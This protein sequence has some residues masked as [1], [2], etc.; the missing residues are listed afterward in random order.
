[1]VENILVTGDVVV[2]PTPQIAARRMGSVG[3]MIFNRPERRNAVSLEMWHAIP[4][5]MARFDA[6]PDIRSIVLAGAG[7]DAFIAGAD[8][9]EFEGQRKDAA[10]ALAYE[11]RNTAAYRA[12]AD[13]PKS[14]IAMI[15]GYC[16]GGGV[17]IAAACDIRIAADGA[18]FG[19]PAARLGLAYPPFAVALLLRAVTPSKAKLLIHSARRVSAAEALAFGL[20]DQVV[21]GADL[22]AHVAELT[23]AIADNAPLTIAAAN[24]TIDAT[25]AQGNVEDT[26]RSAILRCFD[27]SDYQEGRKAFMEKRRP[28]F[29]GL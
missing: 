13:S 28:V 5:V 15:D 23:R 19:I 29:R 7:G 20:V 2:S 4:Q 1:M 21:A 14:V 25:F 6:D 11:E 16:I 12:I 22:E 10:A 17:A 24:A 3:Y 27:S 26:A 9:S 8:I 18:T